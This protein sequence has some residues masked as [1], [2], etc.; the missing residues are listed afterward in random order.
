MYVVS[1]YALAIIFTFVTML[2][3]GSWAN[4]QK[5]ASKSWRFELFYWDFVI[6]T[7]IFSTI[8]AFTL[9]STGEVGRSFLVDINQA[10]YGNIGKAFLAGIIFNLANILLVAA[11]AIAGMSVAF[12]VGI[13]IA[14]ILGVILNYIGAPQGNSIFLFTGVGFV[15]LAIIFDAIAYGNH[16]KKTKKVTTKG[17]AISIAA[18]VLMSFFYRFVADS[19]AIDFVNPEAGKLT[20]YTA[21][22]IF[23]CGVFVSNFLFN[24]IFMKKP[25]AGNPVSYKDYFE[26]KF[27]THLTGILGGAIW[28]LGM[29]LSIIAA[30]KAGYAISYGLGQGATLIGAL[31]GVFIWKEFKHASKKTNSF[32]FFMFLFFL[33]GIGLIIAAGNEE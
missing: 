9:G 7:L 28:C 25:V 27:A 26:G 21:V 18:G 32:L 4:T 22:F 14:L 10:D 19:M 31:W 6:G 1:S 15:A 3:W 30:G 24:T 29:S 33:L 16:S 5:L 11:I 2:C 17:I 23:T 13:G 12:P 20:P 8:F